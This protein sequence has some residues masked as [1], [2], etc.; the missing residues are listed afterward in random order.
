MPVPEP[1]L[2]RH[3]PTARIAD[4]ARVGVPGRQLW[5]GVWDKYGRPTEI[6]AHC[7]IRDFCVIGDEAVIGANSILNCYSWVDVGAEV[8]SGTLL[9]H[10]ASIG[11][12]ALIG[13]DC[14][15][16]GKICERAVVGNRCR[17]FGDVIHRQLD[18][19]MPW[20]APKSQED[21]PTLEDDVFVGWGATIIGGITV[22]AGSYVCAG[23]VV[24]RDVKPRVIISRVNDVCQPEAWPGPLA[25]SAFFNREQG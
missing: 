8:G 23:A 15:I 25:R 13:N 4:S 3:A 12:R 18:P 21:A 11:A 6:G 14:V 10:R 5:E 17:V 7:E 19:T 20:D 24:T 1:P 16:G 2:Y 9:I 22:G